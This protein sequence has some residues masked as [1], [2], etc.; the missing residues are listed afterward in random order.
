M[1]GPAGLAPSDLLHFAAGFADNSSKRES[2]RAVYPAQIGAENQERQVG[3]WRGS[4]SLAE[5]ETFPPEA[6]RP[7]AL[8]RAPHH[9]R[10][11]IGHS[12]LAAAHDL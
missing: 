8:Q 6:L 1:R 12:A 7:D 11:R 4:S 5:V 9:R 2:I 10:Y 3:S